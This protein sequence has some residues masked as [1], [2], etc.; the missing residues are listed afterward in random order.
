MRP[1]VFRA[2]SR[3]ADGVNTFLVSF[4]ILQLRYCRL[5]CFMNF[6]LQNADCGGSV[7]LHVCG[8]QR[9]CYM[10]EGGGWWRRRGVWGGGKGEFV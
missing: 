1:S 5:Y 8:G 4:Y 6:D 2:A 3:F 9:D 7:G 10:K